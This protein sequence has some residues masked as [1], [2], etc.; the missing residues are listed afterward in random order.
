MLLPGHH[1]NV[2]VPKKHSPH[3]AEWLLQLKNKVKGGPDFRKSGFGAFKCRSDV[4]VVC[5]IFLEH[6]AKGVEMR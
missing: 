3:L 6:L 5:V 2:P 1:L 4:G